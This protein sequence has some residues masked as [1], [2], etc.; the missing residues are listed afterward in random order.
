MQIICFMWSGRASYIDETKKGKKERG[1]MSKRQIEGKIAGEREKSRRKRARLERKR[2]ERE[3]KRV[4]RRHG[5]SSFC[6]LCPFSSFAP[7]HTHA[8]SLLRFPFFVPRLSARLCPCRARPHAR[9]SLLLQNKR[10]GLFPFFF[11]FLFNGPRGRTRC[12]P[13]C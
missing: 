4:E 9:S 3:S 7:C 5:L 12:V 6:P 11:P 13:A 8:Q 2:K 10:D 1:R